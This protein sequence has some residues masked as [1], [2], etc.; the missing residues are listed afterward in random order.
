MIIII[1]AVVAW[2]SVCVVVAVVQYIK[3]PKPPNGLTAKE[4]YQYYYNK[5]WLIPDDEED[6]LSEIHKN[7]RAALL[8]ETIIKYNKLLDSLIEQHNNTYNETEKTK[9]L[10][11]QIAT[12]EKLNR[13]LEKREKLE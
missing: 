2:L 8:D 10:T 4:Y 7:E 6:N 3:E 13:A 5:E 9:L 12:M 1:I 11:K